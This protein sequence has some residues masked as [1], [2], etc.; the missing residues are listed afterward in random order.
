[1]NILQNETDLTASDFHLIGHSLGAHIAGYAGERVPN[2]G[3]ITGLDP[4]EPYFQFMPVTV[5]LDMTDAQFVDVIHSDSKSIIQFGLG[6]SQAIG[7]VDFYPNGGLDQPGC[8]A[9]RFISF[10]TEGLIHGTRQFVSCN[11][12][13]AIDYFIE[14]LKLKNGFSE[15]QMIGYLCDSWTEFIKGIC[16]DC[17]DGKCAPMG[18]D[19]WKWSRF[20]NMNHSMKMYLQTADESPFLGKHF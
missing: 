8:S 13:R 10:I 19:A 17:L 18:I 3:R 4:A 14:S 20:K 9:N 11:H 15:Y 7:H 6:M 5:R 1:M 2:L 12:Q 16:S